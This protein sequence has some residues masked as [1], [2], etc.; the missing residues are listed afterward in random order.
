MP[1]YKLAYQLLKQSGWTPE[2][3]I[4][5][6]KTYPDL[7]RETFR[8]KRNRILAK[9]FKNI[10]SEL[11]KYCGINIDINTYYGDLS[12]YL[13]HSLSFYSSQ[14]NYYALRDFLQEDIICIGQS[15]EEPIYMNMHGEIYQVISYEPQLYVMD[16]ILHAIECNYSQTVEECRTIDIEPFMVSAGIPI[17]R[18]SSAT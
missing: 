14:S 1:D 13:P 12:F 16:N 7:F 3:R 4:D 9:K 11:E 5:L 6:E 2:H 8:V 18:S 17:N 15:V 10:Q